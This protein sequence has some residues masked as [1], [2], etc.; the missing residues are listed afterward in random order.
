MSDLPT[1]IKFAGSQAALATAIGVSQPTVSE[2]LRGE[3]P[4]PAALCCAIEDFTGGLVACEELRADLCWSRI[5]D[6]AW[7]ANKGGRPVLDV[8]KAAA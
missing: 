1:A 4:I 3:R 5:A 8:S 2:W 7:T 6:A